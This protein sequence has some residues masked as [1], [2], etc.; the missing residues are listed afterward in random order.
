MAALTS[1]S[2]P[3]KSSTPVSNSF[4]TLETPQSG[5][6]EAS[7]VPNDTSDSPKVTK[8]GGSRV[9]KTTKV[10]YTLFPKS[11]RPECINESDTDKDDI[12][13]S[14]GPSLGGG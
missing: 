13:S 4:D 9:S 3:G 7:T 8:A 5:F 2:L 11:A 14:Y 6:F 1:K 10:P 12:V